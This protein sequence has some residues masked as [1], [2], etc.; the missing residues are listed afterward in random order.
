MSVIFFNIYYNDNSKL[1]IKSKSYTTILGSSESKIT[2]DISKKI[3]Y[4]TNVFENKISLLFSKDI[5]K[6]KTKIVKS[7]FNYYLNKIYSKEIKDKIVALLTNKFDINNLLN[8]KVKEL[9]DSEKIY[10][11]FIISFALN[12]NIIIIDN[13]LNEIDLDKRKKIIDYL[14][15][16]TK[17]GNIVIN[18]TQ[19]ISESIYSKRIIII[20]ENK[21]II[22]GTVESVLQNDVIVKEAGYN[23][24]FIYDL[25]SYLRDYGICSKYILNYERLVHELWK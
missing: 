6:F 17:H 18:L 8:K 20:N 10:I 13:L 12:P 15:T 5:Y 11:K 22:D 21:K 24:P 4:I 25:N 2:N 9:N 7:E 23:L 14:K 1:T 3:N 16:F 19:N